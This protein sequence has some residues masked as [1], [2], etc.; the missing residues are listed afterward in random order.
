M[1]AQCG[2]H[3]PNGTSTGYMLSRDKQ[4]HLSSAS[5]TT[6]S[7]EEMINKLE[8][9][10][11]QHHRKVARLAMLFKIFSVKVMVDS[12]N[13]IPAH[14][15]QK[16]R[17]CQTTCT[18]SVLH[19]IWTGILLSSSQQPVRT[20]MTCLKAQWQQALQTLLRQECH[21]P[22]SNT[23]L[24]FFFSFFFAWQTLWKVAE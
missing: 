18:D 19:H 3:T 17:T 14:P 24:P 16:K 6:P 20:G 23:T 2:I 9:P 15:R 11:L 10:S 21:R 22:Y 5:T 4:L 12:S 8:W 1:S 13:L 7:V